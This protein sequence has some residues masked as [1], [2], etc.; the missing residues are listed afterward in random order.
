MS[1]PTQNS[2]AVYMRQPGDTPLQA[3]AENSCRGRLSFSAPH[4][5]EWLPVRARQLGTTTTNFPRAHAC[6]I[7]PKGLSMI[8]RRTQ[9]KLEG[10]PVCTVTPLFA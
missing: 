6:P 3:S 10:R 5:V 7:P 2:P 1:Q 4:D 8:S 9:K